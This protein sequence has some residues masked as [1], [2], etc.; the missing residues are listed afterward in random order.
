[1]G[2]L[3]DKDMDGVSGAGEDAA[4]G[5]SDGLG[6]AGSCLTSVAKGVGTGGG[7]RGR[8]GLAGALPLA[9]ALGFSSKMN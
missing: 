5:T 9:F 1:M 8:G 4:A 7:T 3:T 2:S 6:V